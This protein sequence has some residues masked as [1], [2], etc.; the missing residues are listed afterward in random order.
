MPTVKSV[1]IRVLRQL[2][3]FRNL[4]ESECR[5]VAEIIKPLQFHAG[6]TIV[7]QGESSRNLWILQTGVC[8]VTKRT[9]PERSDS[10]EIVLAIIEPPSYFGEMSFFN[11]APNSANVRARTDMHVLRISHGDYQDLINEGVWAVY[12][13]AYNVIQGL[14][15]RMRRMDEWV[16]ELLH[17]SHPEVINVPEWNQF[18]EKMLNRW[19]VQESVDGQ[20]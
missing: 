14:S 12:K 7:K 16:T 11:P 19:K 6:D 9:R 4:N 10:E 5:Q 2:P 20:V 8:E 1:D 18:R 3:L 17:D 15:D 13:V